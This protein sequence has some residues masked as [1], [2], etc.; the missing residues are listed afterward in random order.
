MAFNNSKN[1]KQQNFHF[2]TLNSMKFVI[3]H[4]S[5][6]TEIFFAFFLLLLLPKYTMNTYVIGLKIFS[7]SFQRNKKTNLEMNL[8]ENNVEV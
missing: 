3:P 2:N 7:I 6:K 8:R 4:E 5:E 1:R